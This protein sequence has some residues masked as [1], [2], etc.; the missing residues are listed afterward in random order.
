MRTLRPSTIK[1]SFPTAVRVPLNWVG[2]RS[3][4][5]STG[6]LMMSVFSVP[7]TESS[8]FCTGAGVW[9]VIGK[10]DS[11]GNCCTRLTGVF[12]GAFTKA[13]MA[14]TRASVKGAFLW[15][16]KESFVASTARSSE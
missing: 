5:I 12:V 1:A 11:S 4:S 15:A 10:G 9:K 7:R 13:S 6:L 8:V 2:V 3:F 14:T 16:C